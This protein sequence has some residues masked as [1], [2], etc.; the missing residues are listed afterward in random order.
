MRPPTTPST[1]LKDHG[2]KIAYSESVAEGD[3][4][5]RVLREY[6][7][8]GFEMIVAHCFGYEDAAFQVAT[9]Y[10]KTNFAWAG[11]IKKTAKN[12]A[13]YDQPFYEAA[14]PIGVFAGNM[15]KTGKL[16]ALYGFDIPVCHA[17]GEAMLAGAKTRQPQRQ[18]DRHRGRRL[19]RR[20]Q[21]QGSR[22]GPGRCGR[23]LLD[24]MR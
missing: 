20:R 23:R 10:P 12:V 13:D 17:M 21:G 6:A 7:D 18:A 15:S 19:G 1:S 8:Q 11:G 3:D 16:G 24:R 9:E 22:A 4:S 2:V 5:A 14:Y